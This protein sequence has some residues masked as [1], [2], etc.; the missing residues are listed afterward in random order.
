M[1]KEYAQLTGSSSSKMK[2]LWHKYSPHWFAK[3]LEELKA[4]EGS[5]KPNSPL[6][7]EEEIKEQMIRWAA[8]RG[9]VR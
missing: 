7:T 8:E 3:E 2:E 6:R 1:S 4:N 9:G 5:A